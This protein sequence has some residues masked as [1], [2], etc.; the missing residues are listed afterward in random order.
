[1]FILNR[2]ILAEKPDQAKKFAAALK[3]SAAPL[4]NLGGKYEV[5]TDNLGKVTVTWAIG[6]LVGLAM[7]EEY[8]FLKDS[9][10]YDLNSLPI[11]PDQN[12]MIYVVQKGKESQFRVVKSCLEKADEIIIATDPDPE[13][14]N[15]AY[16]IFKLCNR[17]VMSKPMKRLWINSLTSKEIKRGFNNLKA[18]KETMP[19][20]EQANAR[21]ISDWLVGMN[22]SRLYGIKLHQQGLS[23]TISLGRVQTP[24]NTLVVEN[25]MAI[26]NFKPQPYKMLECKTTEK[27]PSVTFKNSKEYFDMNEFESDTK[28]FRLANADHGVIKNIEVT[29]KFQE[30][31]KLFSLGGIQGYANKK[32]KYSTSQTLKI[33][34]SLY[35]SEFLTY[36]RTDC[37]LITENEYLYLKEHLEEYKNV[38]GLNVKTPV[39]EPSKRYVNSEAVLEHYAIIPTT[40]IPNLSTLTE[41]QRNIYTAVT[42]ITCLMFAEPYKYQNTTVILDVNEMEFKASGNVPIA[43]GWKAVEEDPE[44]DPVEDIVLPAFVLN[45]RVSITVRELDKVTKEPKRLTEGRLVGKGGLMS[46]LGLGTSATRA[47]IVETLINRGYIKIENTKVFPTHTGYLIFDLTKNLLIGKPEYTAQWES[48]LSKISKGN[49]TREKFVS[50]IHKF[51]DTKV[52]EMKDIPFESPYLEA[53]K[54][55]NKFQVAGYTLEE[56]P[57]LFE[58]VEDST[59]E[60]FKIFKSFS[61]KKLTTK[62][63]K[64]LLEFGKTKSEVKGL[65]SKS[66]SKYSAFLVFDKET[67][68]IKPSFDNK[69]QSKET[70]KEISCGIYT[71]T[72]KGSVF[73]I[74][75]NENNENFILFKKNSGKLLTVAIIKELLL[76]GKTSKKITGFEKQAGGKYSAFLKFDKKTKK[77]SKSFD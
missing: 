69:E 64:E 1:M 15:I 54:N 66:K 63:I 51:I 52:N 6:H 17:S 47:N 60:A 67:K 30:S 4:K 73:E 27:Q 34:Q 50:N 43:K 21:Q 76:K 58:V 22:F 44:S 20:Y 18:A 12:K 62:L 45:E 29:E 2:V 9:D 7:P 26:K 41:E 16:N 8:S 46:K 28:K 14:E 77:I 24:V 3:N 38:I 61:G 55:Q 19:F 33:I 71:I 49:G 57:Y 40:N 68:T 48:Y 25:D 72:E 31:P 10:R 74:K 32:W 42:K 36:P 56:T 59:G 11:L 65:V 5:E 37:E 13:G 53:S 75:D 35:Q 70:T 39:M 23:G